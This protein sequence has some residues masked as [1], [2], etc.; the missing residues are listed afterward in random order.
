MATVVPAAQASAPAV[1]IRQTRLLIDGK[2]V[3]AAS[4][5]RFPTF[6]PATGEEISRIVE[7][8][9]KMPPELLARAVAAMGP[10]EAEPARKK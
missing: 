10:M 4:G 1:P 7:S 2:W 8:T 3:D 5:K 6:N 9:L